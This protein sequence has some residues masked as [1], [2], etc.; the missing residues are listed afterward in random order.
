MSNGAMTLREL[1]SV[2]F[3]LQSESIEGSGG[4]WLRVVSYPELGCTV[5]S[6]SMV[7][8]AEEVERCKVRTLVAAVAAGRLPETRRP[9]GAEVGIEDLLV[10][11]GLENWIDSLDQPIEELVNA[12]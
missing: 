1:L 5:S 7:E 12:L 3:L 4:G 6:V 11:A 9:Y 10:V 2:P 8:A